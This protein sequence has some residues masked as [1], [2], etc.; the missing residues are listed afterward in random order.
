MSSDLG[1]TASVARQRIFPHR[2]VLQLHTFSLCAPAASAHSSHLLAPDQGR[3]ANTLPGRPHLRGT[4]QASAASA[5]RSNAFGPPE[6]VT[7]NCKAESA[8]QKPCLRRTTLRACRSRVLSDAR[9]LAP[10]FCVQ[11]RARA[12]L[13]LGRYIAAIEEGALLREEQPRDGARALELH[14]SGAR[15][16]PCDQVVPGG[17]QAG[18]VGAWRHLRGAYRTHSACTIV[19]CLPIVVHR[20]SIASRL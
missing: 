15:L 4:S 10:Q 1:T 7:T 20:V 2:P 5:R 11:Q 18:N 17:W 13:T 12:L 3:R 8:R 14:R 19:K 16:D 9:A 6:G